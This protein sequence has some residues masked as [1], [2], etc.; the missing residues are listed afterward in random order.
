MLLWKIFLSI[1]SYSFL[2]PNVE[3]HDTKLDLLNAKTLHHFSKML[4]L[5]HV[6]NFKR[7]T[8]IN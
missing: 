8:V 5:S 4:H 2:V 6:K 3:K 7:R 1:F